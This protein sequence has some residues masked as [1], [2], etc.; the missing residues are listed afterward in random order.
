MT[1]AEHL[2]YARRYLTKAEQYLAS[3][4]DNLDLER[5]IPAAGRPPEPPGLG[6]AQ[7]NLMIAVKTPRR[8][9]TM[10][11]MIVI[12]QKNCRRSSLCR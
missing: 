8:M 10:A 4:Q 11:V 12:S 1:S 5:A 6:P 9:P 2:N 3:A 7:I